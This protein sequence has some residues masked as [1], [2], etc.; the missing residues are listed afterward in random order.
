MPEWPLSHPVL[1]YNDV[2]M[3]ARFFP[4]KNK[5]VSVIETTDEPRNILILTVCIS[6]LEQ[7]TSFIGRDRFPA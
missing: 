1:C 6:F 5:G 3:T 2:A 4:L 7:L